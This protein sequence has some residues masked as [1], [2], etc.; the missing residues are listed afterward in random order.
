[1][2]KKV[3]NRDRGGKSKKRYSINEQIKAKEVRLIDNKGNQVGVVPIEKAKEMSNDLNLDL[4]LISKDANPPVCKIADYGQFLYQE[5][6]REKQTKKTTQTIKELKLSHNIS[7][8]DY[9]VRLN[10]AKKFL[11]KKYK[12]KL[13]VVF[14]GRHIIYKNDHGIKI[15]ERFLEDIKEYGTKDNQ[16]IRPTRNLSIMINPK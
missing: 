8:G 2:K 1:M 5:K 10:H 15:V 11:T 6:K 3:N 16:E 4:L 9:N 13:T 14:R 7:I 12:V